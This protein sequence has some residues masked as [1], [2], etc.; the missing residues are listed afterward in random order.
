MVGPNWGAPLWLNKITLVINISK[1]YGAKELNF[2]EES[3]CQPFYA[4][5]EEVMKE[6]EL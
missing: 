6:D 2:N 5:S 4:L 3:C 1:P